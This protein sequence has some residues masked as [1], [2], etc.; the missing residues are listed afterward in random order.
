VPAPPST[1]KGTLDLLAEVLDGSTRLLLERIKSGEATA[2]DLNVAR[3]LL[4]D[5][6]INAIPTRDNGIGRLAQEL[7][8]QSS[9]EIADDPSENYH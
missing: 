5:N 3:Q 9:A 6:G 2:A 4:K 7:P 8:F 1:K